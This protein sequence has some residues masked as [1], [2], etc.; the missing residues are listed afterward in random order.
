MGTLLRRCPARA[1][2]PV[3]FLRRRTTLAA[4]RPGFTCTLLIMAGLAEGSAAPVAAQTP[5]VPSAALPGVVSPITPIAPSRLP[6]VAPGLGAPQ[7]VEP[8]EVP[9]VPRSIS[10][11]SIV[12]ATAYP[13]AMLNAL[14]AGLTGPAVPQQRIEDARAALVNLYRGDGYIA[15]TVQAVLSAGH[16]RFVVTEGRIIEVK[17]DG[18][19]GPAGT[20]VLRFLNHLTEVQPLTVT[21]LERWLLLANDIPGLTVKSVLNPSAGDPGA[22][23]L[24]AQVSR[25]P[26]GGLFTSDNRAFQLT[27]PEE[28]LTIV[29][30]NSFTE[31]G[32]RT[33]AQIYH[34]YNNTQTFGQ[35]SSDFFIGG[36]G[37]KGRVYGGSGTA[38]PSGDLRAIGYDAT[39]TTFGGDLSYPVIRARAES[40]YVRGIFDAIETAIDTNTGANGTSARASFDSLRILRAQAEYTLLDTW[41]GDD[42][43]ATD[44]V[45]GRVSQGLHLLGASA[46]GA[47][48]AGRVGQTTDF[49]KFNGQIS[50]AQT[51]FV[52]WEEATV[53]L[54][55]VV[56]GQGTG[57]ILPPAE[58]FYLGGPHFNRGYYYGQVTGDNALTTSVELQLNTPVPMPDFVPPPITTRAQFYAFY[59]WGETWENQKLDA[60]RVLRSIGGGVRLFVTEFTEFDLE[61]T[62]RLNPY[63]NGTSGNVSAIKS[64][65]FY[66]QALARF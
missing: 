48:D 32:E 34:T 51:L 39:T 17:L 15:T 7:A 23:T 25:R 45:S 47:S 5:Q 61:G 19:I 3:T 62:V 27:G 9:N 65:A 20:Q 36:S 8:A 58:K 50:R 28:L 29:D 55:G 56:A 16:L 11:V 37:L 40:L 18:D 43:P 31:F 38:T 46:N 41:L 64:G 26:Y 6:S 14:V 52:P 24:V 63:P 66:W 2:V 54:Q 30:F 53:A 21:A 59:D 12:G 22:L 44:G 13:S 57:N 4:R 60:N 33:E 49:T 42:L 10:D 1:R 35:A